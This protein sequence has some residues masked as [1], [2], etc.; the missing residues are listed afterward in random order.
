V[1]IRVSNLKNVL[2]YFNQLLNNSKK[3]FEK[4]FKLV[5]SK[6]PFLLPALASGLSSFNCQ[7]VNYQ[8]LHS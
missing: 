2:E 1:Q 7:H 8:Q 3:Y 6:C 5:K 4:E